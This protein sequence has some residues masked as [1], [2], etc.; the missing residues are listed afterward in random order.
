M[1]R[2]FT[3]L[4]DVLLALR[5]GKRVQA[6][7][8]ARLAIPASVSSTGKSRVLRL[9]VSKEGLD[10]LTKA[11]SARDAA[12]QKA[13]EDFEAGVAALREEQAKAQKAAW[14]ELNK[15][16]DKVGDLR[17]GSSKKKSKDESEGDDVKVDGDDDDDQ[18][19]TS[20]P[21]PVAPAPM[22]VPVAPRPPLVGQVT[23]P[24]L[25]PVQPVQQPNPGFSPSRPI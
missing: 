20:V 21:A 1:A 18:E 3:V 14:T 15:I 23:T 9:D 8:T 6:N 12:I 22:D 17:P 25:A 4:D 2:V 11:Y 10:L 19:E 7:Q 5:N 13:E 24:S 16:A